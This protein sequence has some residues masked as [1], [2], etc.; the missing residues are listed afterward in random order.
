MASIS[1]SQ[2]KP[3]SSTKNNLNIS[4]QLKRRRVKLN[5]QLISD[6]VTLNVSF[7]R[8]KVSDNRLE[9]VLA[10]R[11]LSIGSSKCVLQTSR[12]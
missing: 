2:K 12:K 11:L 5:F 8:S 6:Q 3:F 1:I 4:I 7:S 10:L 9:G